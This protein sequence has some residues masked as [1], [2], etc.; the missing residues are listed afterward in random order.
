MFTIKKYVVA[1][2]LEEAYKLNQSKK[3]NILGGLLWMKMG[4]KTIQT[5]ID[6]SNLGLDKI[7]ENDEYFEIGAMVR[8]RDLE[9]HEGLNKYF[10]NAIENCVKSIVGVQF[11]NCAT[12]GGSIFSRF[13][14][15]DPLTCLLALDSYV[16]LYKGGVISMREFVNMPYD[17]D[18]LE[19]VIIKK[20]N[21]KIS[22]MSHRNISTDFPVLTC[23]VSKL[24]D[25]FAVA[26]GARPQK[27]VLVLDEENI[28][29]CDPTKD[30]IEKFADYLYQKENA[31]ATINKYM[32]DIKKFLSFLADDKLTFGSN[33]RA[34]KDFRSHL[35]K[36]L[37]KRCINEVGGM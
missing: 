30:E 12:I 25:K 19:K 8:L 13:G 36:V 22:Y 21:R 16:K 1:D 20:D 10:N 32:A 18:I 23:A 2:S 33:M 15:S 27:A 3:A 26:V 35:C 4:H 14:F 17:N 29:S 24:G 31:K 28:L 34:S 37:V 7:E 11:R 9:V 5:A 6:L